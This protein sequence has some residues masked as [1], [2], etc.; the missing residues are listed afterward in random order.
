MT[1][2]GDTWPQRSW[3]VLI[4][5]IAFSAPMASWNTVLTN[6]PNGDLLNWPTEVTELTGW[7]NWLTAKYCSVVCLSKEKIPQLLKNQKGTLCL[8]AFSYFTNLFFF[9]FFF[10]FPLLLL[11]FLF[12]DTNYRSNLFSLCFEKLSFNLLIR[13]PF[14]KSN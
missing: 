9:F 2:M 6:W 12:F 3:K 14:C 8:L 5:I 13:F 11:Q 4:K 10:A 1:T 7:L